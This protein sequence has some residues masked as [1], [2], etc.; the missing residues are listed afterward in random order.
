MEQKKRT[1]TKVE[2]G[3]KVKKTVK[4]AAEASEAVEEETKNVKKVETL[5]KSEE[6]SKATTLRIVAAI[7][8][9]FA[10]GFEVVAIL[11]LFKKLYIPWLPQMWGMIICIVLDLACCGCC[12]AL[13]ESKPP[14]SVQKDQQQSR[15]LHSHA[16]RR[17]HGGNLLHP[18]DRP[19]ASEQG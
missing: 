3:E 17:H 18:A 10:I 14:R 5:S 7:L 9:A 8:W 1:I 12:T 2:D 11:F 16:A 6:K 15:L 4:K 13:E 19:R